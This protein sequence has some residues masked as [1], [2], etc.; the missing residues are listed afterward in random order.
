[1]WSP[2]LDPDTGGARDHIWAL[3]EIQQGY[4][5]ITY[6]QLYDLLIQAYREIQNHLGGQVELPL[7]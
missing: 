5:A 7:S 6:V 4:E 2:G 3:K 1:V